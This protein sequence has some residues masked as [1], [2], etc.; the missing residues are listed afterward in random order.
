MGAAVAYAAL[1]QSPA[2][3]LA[4]AA[5]DGFETHISTD[6][7][8]CAGAPVSADSAGGFSYAPSP[9]PGWWRVAAAPDQTAAA[10]EFA[11][12]AGAGDALVAMPEGGLD[13]RLAT[14]LAPMLGAATAEPLTGLPLIELPV[15]G[16]GRVMAVVFSGDGGWRDIDKDIAGRLQQRGIPVVGVDSLRYFWSEKT[17]EEVASDLG[18]IMGHYR[19]AWQ[20]PDVVLAGYSFGADILPFVYNRLG[21]QERAQV[22]DLALLGFSHSAD[23]EIHV[24]GWLGVTKQADSR[25]TAPE[26]AK[27]PVKMVQC[28]Y[29]KD[30]TD[31]ACTS[32]ELSGARLVETP[33]GHHFDGDYGKLADAIVAATEP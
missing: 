16:P 9:L 20:R 31:T 25:P 2:A 17:P 33:G 5:S 6:S 29:G 13:E 1:A 3:T 24:T 4:G 21:E 22:T 23:F 12:A 32:P 19:N 27:L 28:F 14:L 10:E 30:D 8:L 15:D 7:P 26:L 18:R 11:A